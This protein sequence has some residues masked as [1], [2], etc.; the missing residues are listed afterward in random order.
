MGLF[1]HRDCTGS[2]MLGMIN[3]SD[4]QKEMKVVDQIKE[5]P[6]ATA[7]PA[8]PTPDPITE[9]KASSQATSSAPAV[10]AGDAATPEPSSV[11]GSSGGGESPMIQGGGASAEAQASK[12]KQEQILPT[13]TS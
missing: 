8:T 1:A 6:A 10:P 2:R 11:A 13:A 12:T 7:I 9:A 4:E 5:A 3:S